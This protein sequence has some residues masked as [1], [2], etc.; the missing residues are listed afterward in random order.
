MA[1]KMPYITCREGLQTQLPHGNEVVVTLDVVVCGNRDLLPGS[2][3]D[4]LV[5]VFKEPC[6]DFW[7]LHGHQAQCVQVED[8]CT[9]ASSQ[10]TSRCQGAST[11]WAKD[12]N[13]CCRVTFRAGEPHGTL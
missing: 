4:G 2:Q 12:R 10:K 3:L 13:L 6:P 11:R 8:A 7:P 5:W 1:T 9:L